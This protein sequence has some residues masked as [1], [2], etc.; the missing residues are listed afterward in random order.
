MYSVFIDFTSVY[1]GILSLPFS[2]SLFPF[3]RLPAKHRKFGRTWMKFQQQKVFPSKLLTLWCKCFFEQLC[4]SPPG[5]LT[6]QLFI[7]LHRSHREHLCSW[8]SLF[9]KVNEMLMLIWNNFGLFC[10]WH[11]GGD[12]WFSFKC[13][14]KWC[15]G[16][17]ETADRRKVFYLNKNFL[18]CGFKCA[19][20]RHLQKNPFQHVSY[21]QPSRKV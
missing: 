2:I 12:E 20:Q 16:G 17:S 11:Q 8:V 21:E 5:L 9:F 7:H 13:I 6:L 15:W 14:F 19:K 4:R 1:G 10:R 3:G 18:K